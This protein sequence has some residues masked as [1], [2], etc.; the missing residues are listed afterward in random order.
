[1]LFRGIYA[2]I[3]TPFGADG[4]INYPVLAKLVDFLID[5]GI[6]G[7]VPGGTTGEVYAFS[8]EE[9]LEVFRFVKVL[10]LNSKVCPQAI[11]ASL[12]SALDQQTETACPL[13]PC[14]GSIRP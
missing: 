4:A 9:R 8:D 6:A 2:P 14:N 1:M 5:N 11:W 7:L 12:H 13:A 10:A 3:V